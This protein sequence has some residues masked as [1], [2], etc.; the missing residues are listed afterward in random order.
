MVLSQCSHFWCRELLLLMKITANIFGSSL[1]KK[2]V[3]AVTGGLLFLFVVAHMPG[4]MQALNDAQLK[5]HPDFLILV[6]REIHVRKDGKY[7]GLDDWNAE[8]VRSHAELFARVQPDVPRLMEWVN[9][10]FQAKVYADDFSP[11][12]FIT[13]NNDDADSIHEYL[14]EYCRTVP[15]LVV[16]R[17]DVYAR[18]RDRKSVV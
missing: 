14:N 16:V 4:L 2:Y 3:M 15:N 8:C 6:E 12:C 5:V 1:G 11:F 9:A 7:A 13:G 10:R 18:F 17:N